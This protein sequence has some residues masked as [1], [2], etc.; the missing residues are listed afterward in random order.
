MTTDGKL[1]LER[2]EPR[3]ACASVHESERARR[4]A[5]TLPPSVRRCNPTVKPQF[6]AARPRN[7]I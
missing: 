3:E 6:S 1:E 4:N 2:G 7:P 5:R